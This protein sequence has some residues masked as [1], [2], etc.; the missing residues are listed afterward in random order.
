MCQVYLHNVKGKCIK[1][2]AKREYFGI[3][4]GDMK[5]QGITK[6][7]TLSLNISGKNYWLQLLGIQR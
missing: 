6:K 5:L 7:F 1:F 3:F 4:G 2:L